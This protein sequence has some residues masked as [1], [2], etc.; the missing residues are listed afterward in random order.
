MHP[1]RP[2]RYLA[3]PACIGSLLLYAANRWLL[4]P[5]HIGGPIAHDYLNDLLCLPLF[6]P[7]ILRVQR[8]VGLRHHDAPPRLWEILQ[9]AI[10]FSIIFEVVLPKYPQYFHTTADPLDAVAYFAGGLAVATLLWWR[11]PAPACISTYPRTTTH[12][13][14][15]PDGAVT[16]ATP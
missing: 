9:H 3:D 5:H 6:L 2:F 14:L 4:K 1:T 8:L 16:P 10:V 11:D 15:S 12:T 13:P 7:M